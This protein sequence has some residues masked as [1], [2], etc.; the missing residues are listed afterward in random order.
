M[1]WARL[2]WLSFLYCIGIHAVCASESPARKEFIESFGPEASEAAANTK[3]IGPRSGI[4]ELIDKIDA[5]ELQSNELGESA[6]KG[7]EFRTA[8]KPTME[9]LD[10]TQSTEAIRL[11][12]KGIYSQAIEELKGFLASSREAHQSRKT[13]ATILLAQGQVS[14]ARKFLEQG[15]SLAPNFAPF[16]KLYARIL[17]DGSPEDAVR[18]LERLPP[19]IQQDPEYH[20][21]YAVALQFNQQFE[22]AALIFEALLQVDNGNASWWMGLALSKDAVG[23]YNDAES[24]YSM[25]S[26]LGERNLILSQ[27]GDQRLRTL[28]G[29]S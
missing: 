16:K 19:E 29:G 22:S 11:V 3:G 7:T 6:A 15:L 2:P 26:Q 28:R 17:L 1:R 12:E 20:Q 18:L 4:A 25:A 10:L 23:E 14:E 5:L 13:L 8:R 21:I 24:A 27:Y 9:E